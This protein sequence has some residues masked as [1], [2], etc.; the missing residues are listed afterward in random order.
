MTARI[1]PVAEYARSGLWMVCADAAGRDV[2]V[3]VS[4]QT[5]VDACRYYNGCLRCAAP[6][7][8]WDIGIGAE[9]VTPVLK[10]RGRFLGSG[11][12]ARLCAGYIVR[13]PLNEL[14]FSTPLNRFY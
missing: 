10:G 3:P 5:L 7:W 8:A 14:P 11:F 12:G 4:R 2:M 13:D 1:F 6:F 9:C